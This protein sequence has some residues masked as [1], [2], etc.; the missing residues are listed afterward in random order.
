MFRPDSSLAAH[1]SGLF[2]KVWN[3]DEVPHFE[4]PITNVSAIFRFLDSIAR[5]E[6]ATTA[7]TDHS[8]GKRKP[9]ARVIRASSTCKPTYQE[10]AT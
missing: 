5:T 9:R 4:T 8:I 7:S 1:I 10:E 6:S 2:T 3:I